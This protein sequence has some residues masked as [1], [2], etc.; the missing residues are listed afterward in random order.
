MLS[1]RENLQ[2][3]LSSTRQLLVC[4]MYAYSFPR[5]ISPAYDFTTGFHLQ[6]EPVIVHYRGPC[7][8][9]T[10]FRGEILPKLSEC[11]VHPPSQ[12]SEGLRRSLRPGQH[13]RG[14]VV[15]E[16]DLHI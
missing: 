10:I 9:F 11:K 1:S 14:S 7:M 4:V 8:C 2:L 6:V 15:I 3:P 13:T 16:T 12:G 5:I